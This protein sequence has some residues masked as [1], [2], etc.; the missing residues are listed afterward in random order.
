MALSKLTRFQLFVPLPAEKIIIPS[1][2]LEFL[3][4]MPDTVEMKESLPLDKMTHLKRMI[5][6]NL[7]SQ[8]QIQF[9]TSVLYVVL[10]QMRLVGFYIIL[11]S[12]V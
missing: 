3:G 1:I 8:W 12:C 4:I 9:K 2:P 10:V 11:H 6:S 5:N 7:I